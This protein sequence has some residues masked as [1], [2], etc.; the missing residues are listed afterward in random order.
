MKYVCFKRVSSYGNYRQIFSIYSKPIKITVLSISYGNKKVTEKAKE[1]FI[2]IDLNEFKLHIAFKKGNELTFHFNSPSRRFYLSLIAFVVNEMKKLGKITSIP[3]EGHLDLL[4]LLNDTI[5]G[6]A[7]SPDRENLLPRI[8][9]KWVY[10]LP[11]LEAAPLFKVLGRKKEYDEGSGKTYPFTEN[12]KGSWANLFEYKGSE[13][14]VRL[15]FAIDRIGAGLDDVHIIYEGSINDD[16]WEKFISSLRDKVKV[17]PKKEETGETHQESLDQAPLPRKWKIAWP[18]RYRWAILIVA[19]GAVAGAAAMA[20]WGLYIRHAPPPEVTLSTGVPA[21]GRIIGEVASPKKMAFP[22]PE[23]PSIAVL[24]FVNMSG[25]PNQE[26][27]S[28]GIT[29]TIITT[30][31]KIPD[32]FVIAR[33]STF[34]YKGKP[35]KV[36]QVSEELGVRYV[37]EGSVQK[38]AD[39]VRVSAQLV[40]ALRGHHLWAERYDRHIKELFALQDEMTREIVLALRVKLTEGEQALVRHRSTNNLDA[41]GHAIRAYSLF[42]RYTKEDNAKARE[43]FE[44]AV[45]LDPNYAWAWTFLAWTHWI[46]TRYFTQSKAKEESF[47]RAVELAQKSLKL[48]EKDPD[49]HAL[50]GGI[51][52]FQRQYPEAVAAGERSVVLGPNNAENLV[53]LGHTLLFV[54]RFEEA[55]ELIQKAMRLHPYYPPWYLVTLGSSLYLSGRYEEANAAYQEV[56]RRTRDIRG[57]IP[58]FA[59]LL[60]A[61]CFGMLG[62]NEEARVQMNEGVK[63]WPKTEGEFSLKNARNWWAKV[64]FYQN[65]AHVEQLL[66]GMRRAGLK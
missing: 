56:I 26:F 18:S 17:E 14:N 52:L 19:I 66:E 22:L 9:R 41:W 21:K 40:D 4:A 3:L 50:L 53:L 16:A 10:A 1:R 55:I 45:E 32:L 25:D 46:D 30:L 39:R 62:R 7:G 57:P 59:R 58:M 49:V 8:Y 27:F 61:S 43:L 35:V 44:R 42:E 33:N 29:E 34:T 12:E 28:D 47:K 37:L 11:D 15:K 20:T 38:S 6:S 51:Y 54:G 31:S 60:S 24:P 5:G 64:T 65:P 13:E 63:L 36:K 23:K 48:S 2:S